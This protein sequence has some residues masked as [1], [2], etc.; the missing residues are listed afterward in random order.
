MERKNTY[1]AGVD[2]LL[3]IRNVGMRYPGSPAS[4]ENVSLSIEPGSFVSILGASGCGKSTL[5]KVVGGLLNPTSGHLRF[6]GERVDGLLSDAIYVFQAYDRSLLPWRTV[7]DNVALGLEAKR[8]KGQYR[9]RG[10]IMKACTAALEAVA[11]G[12]ARDKYPRQ[13]SGGMQ[14]RVALARALV[15]EPKLLLLDETF[16]AVDALSRSGLQDLIL[17]IWSRLGV[18][19]LFVTHD[20]EEAVYLSDRIVVLSGAPG[21]VVADVSV[22]LPRPRHQITTKE[23]P[24]FLHLRR[25]LYSLI[26][27]SENQLPSEV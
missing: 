17:D 19:I 18:T 9:S 5:L 15:C 3:E 13:L 20:I 25:N 1:L 27:S 4:L 21:S 22:Q 2:P 10:E 7:L 8:K 12:S 23:L 11:L 6:N 24:E 14:Q 26:G 16:S